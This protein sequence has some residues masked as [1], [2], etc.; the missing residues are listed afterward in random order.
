M[1]KDN[2]GIRPLADRVLIREVEKEKEEQTTDAGIIIPESAQEEEAH[3][4][5]RGEVIAVGEGKLNDEGEHEPMPVEAGQTVLFS[6]GEKLSVDGEDYQI[7]DKS[8]ILAVI[9]G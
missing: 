3:G 7:V 9:E 6:W 1:A 5:N 4:A 2:V 8:N